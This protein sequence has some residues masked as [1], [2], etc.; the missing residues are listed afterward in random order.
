MREQSGVVVGDLLE[1]RVEKG[2]ITLMP[3]ILLDCHLAEGLDD[4]KKGGT[5]GPYESP[6]RMRRG[7][8]SSRE[9]QGNCARKSS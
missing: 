7:I 5:Q 8:G 1:T 4:V 3:K 2:K 9:N 6:P